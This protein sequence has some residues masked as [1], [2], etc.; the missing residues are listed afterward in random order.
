MAVHIDDTP[1]FGSPNPKARLS[2]GLVRH[3]SAPTRPNLKLDRVSSSEGRNNIIKHPSMLS[4]RASVTSP[5]SKPNLLSELSLT[6]SVV[7]QL[8]LERDEWRTTAQ[9]QQRQLLSNERDLQSQERSIA[10]LEDQNAALRAGHEEDVTASNKLFARL[11]DVII[12]HDKLVDQLNDSV[13]AAARLKKSDRAKG[14]VWQRNLRLKATLQR[15]TSQ[16]TS[17][18]AKQDA[19]TEASLLEALALANER[20]EELESKGEVLLEALDKHNDSSDS[21]KGGDEEDC[22]TAQLLEA[23]VAFRGVLEDETFKEQKGFWQDLL[24][25]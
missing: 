11:Q 14:K 15:Y 7:S 3:V 9:I 13:R 17:G 19:N 20:I 21:R 22:G 5:R 4:P 10:M 12:K 16:M 6:Q 2:R 25:E 18:S 24:R 1:S 8:R 23:E